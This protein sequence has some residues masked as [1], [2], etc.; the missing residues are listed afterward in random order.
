MSRTVDLV[1]AFV[2][3]RPPVAVA[4]IQQARYELLDPD[5]PEGAMQRLPDATVSTAY[6]WRIDVSGR[7]YWINQD[8]DSELLKGLVE[9]DPDANQGP[10]VGTLAKVSVD[11]EALR[12]GPVDLNEATWIRIQA[13]AK[14]FEATQ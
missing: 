1:K 5:D 13:S 4:T 3:K 7:T 10:V 2:I 14:L 6:C 12:Y 9:A 8:Q 11:G